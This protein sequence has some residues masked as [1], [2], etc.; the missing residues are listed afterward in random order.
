MNIGQE[1]EWRERGWINE[2][3]TELTELGER[4]ALWVR[5]QDEI[6]RLGRPFSEYKPGS[7]R[8]PNPGVSRFSFTRPVLLNGVNWHTDGHFAAMGDPPKY[9]TPAGDAT[10][11]PDLERV[12]PKKAGRQIKPV[13]FAVSDKQLRTVFFS[14]GTPVNSTYFDYINKLHKPDRWTKEGD[15]AS[16][17]QAWKGKQLVALLMPMRSDALPSNVEKILKPDRGPE[18]FS[19]GPLPD[20][21]SGEILGSGFGALQTLW[22]RWERR[23]EP[24]GPAATK[25]QL[26]A[27]QRKAREIAKLSSMLSPSLKLNSV[28]P[29][30]SRRA[31][32]RRE[33]ASPSAANSNESARTA[34][35]TRRARSTRN[36]RR[37]SS[38]TR[39]ARTARSGYPASQPGP[40]STPATRSNGTARCASP[41]RSSRATCC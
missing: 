21:P 39:A 34:R 15:S 37:R 23:S 11:A 6:D 25:S 32:H 5:A 40:R 10:R 13:A 17:L 41:L 29:S 22:D 33:S 36:L 28:M 26:R 38:Q 30:A 18:G 2:A 8:I 1:A 3:A 12:M 24:S 35:L 16:P 4:A 31:A 19:I 14:D 27:I 20:E 9:W 7:G